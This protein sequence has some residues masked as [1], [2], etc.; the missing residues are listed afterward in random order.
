[1]CIFNLEET[2]R[3]K[4][5]EQLATN[6]TVSK[7]IKVPSIRRNNVH[8]DV[9]AMYSAFESLPLQEMNI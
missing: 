6:S 3:K 9:I 8:E 4:L 7:T 5:F 2:R 1:M